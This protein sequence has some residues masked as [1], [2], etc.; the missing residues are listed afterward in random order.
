MMR[1]HFTIL[2]IAQFIFRPKLNSKPEKQ[3]NDSNED[4]DDEDEDD[5]ADENMSVRR[6]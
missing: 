3:K 1:S 5:K 6:P 4:G 2:T